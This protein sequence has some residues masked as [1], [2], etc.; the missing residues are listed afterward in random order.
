MNLEISNEP[1][2]ERGSSEKD[3]TFS[4]CTDMK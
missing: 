1:N 2:K 4:M 3:F